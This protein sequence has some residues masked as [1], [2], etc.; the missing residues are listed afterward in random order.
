MEID[1]YFKEINFKGT[2]L[3]PIQ[4]EMPTSFLARLNLRPYER[5][6]STL[7]PVLNLLRLVQV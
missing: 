4:F 1:F 5:G 6:A 7:P 2:N 3:F